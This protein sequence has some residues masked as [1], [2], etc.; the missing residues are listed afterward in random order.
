ML[1]TTSK[2]KRIVYIRH[3]P[4]YKQQEVKTNRTSF[5]YCNH[6]EHHNT[7]LRT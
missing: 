6:N 4:S 1:K 7:E 2:Q 3:E 5:L